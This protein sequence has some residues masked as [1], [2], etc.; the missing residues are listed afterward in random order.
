MKTA[1]TAVLLLVAAA[2]APAADLAIQR[3]A[4]HD[5]EDGPL[6]QPGYEYLPGETV[7]FSARL[8]G[9]TREV[10]DKEQD[11]DRVRLTWQIRP[12]DPAGTLL[13]PPLRGLIEEILRPE[14]KAWNPK[15]NASFEVPQYAPRGVYRIPVVVRDDIAQREITGQVEFRV[16]GEEAPA[17]DVALGL[18]NFRFLADEDSRFAL[19]PAQYK[20]GAAVFARFDILGYGFEGNNRFSVEYGLEVLGAP[21]A[22]GVARQLLLQASAAEESGE[23]FYPQRWVPAGFGFQ[24]APDIAAGTYTLVITLRDKVRGIETQFRDTFQVRE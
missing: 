8:T 24:L 2:A 22:E 21:N 9:Y 23:S 17:A 19:R 5:Y 4:L 3:L 12:A 18:R 14:D 15:F 13:A 6:I 11:L 20:P 16:R 10:A 7:W 1:S